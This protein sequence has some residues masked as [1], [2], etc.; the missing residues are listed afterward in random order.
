MTDQRYG[1][2]VVIGNAPS[3][4]NGLGCTPC[5]CSGK[6][7]TYSQRELADRDYED[8]RA[9]RKAQAERTEKKRRAA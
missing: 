5:G 4:G 1:R 6:V 9:N 2:W 3:T 7:T 8:S